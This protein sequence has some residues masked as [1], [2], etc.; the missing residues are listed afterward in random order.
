[1]PFSDPCAGIGGFSLGLENAG[2]KCIAQVEIDEY[3]QKI[4]TNFWPHVP[5][6]RDLK[7]LDP[8]ELPTPSLICGGYP[9]QPF[10]DAGQ[11]RGADDDRHLWPFIFAIVAA[12]QPAWGLFENVVGHVTMGLDAV[13]A[14][15]E[16]IGYATAP[17]IVPAC[18]VGAAH[19]RNRVWIIA[20]SPG[21]ERYSDEIRLCDSSKS[22]N[23]KRPPSMPSSLSFRLESWVPSPSARVDGDIRKIDGF[24]GWVDT[25]RALGNAV[26]PK[27]VCEIGKAIMAAE[28]EFG[29]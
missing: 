22:L 13:L 14:D 1:V 17:L 4:L 10:S 11:R 9:C 24:P 28:A 18:S 8:A 3:C 2:M 26:V 20:H 27:L 19:R 12:K 21:R 29:R 5:K 25:I 16:S 6:F 15:L 23:R 7:A